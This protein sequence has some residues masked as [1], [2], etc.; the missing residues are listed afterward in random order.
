[1]PAQN[2]GEK[3]L[4]NSRSFLERN[5]ANFSRT[6][7]ESV[8]AEDMVS[9]KG[10]FQKMD[11]RVKVYGILLMI[12]ACAFSRDA[13]TIALIYILSLAFAFQSQVLTGSFFRRIWIFMPFYTALVAIPALFITPGAAWLELPGRM[14]IT[15]QGAQ[16]ALLLILRVATSVS[17]LFLLI[18]TT[19]WPTLLKALRALRFPKLL[20]FLL[21]VTH[22][23]IYVLLHSAN[24]L[25]LAR[26]SRAVGYESWR[27]TWQWLGS[28]VGALLGKSYHLSNEV[29]LAMRSRGFRGEPSTLQQFQ[30]RSSDC[31][32]LVLFTALAGIVAIG[33]FY[34]L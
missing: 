12:L 25:F 6:L 26:K 34:Q 30:L 20:I 17:F 19:S 21:A 33:H 31:V 11:P 2:S 23:Y 7:E 32:W 10:L 5:L 4:N 13:L 29:Y 1:M 9:R 18:I 24:S 8:F 15:K 28:L 16:V 27:T 22:R 14:I 3:Y